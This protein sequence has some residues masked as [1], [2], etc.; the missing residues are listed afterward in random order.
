VPKNQ[1][2]HGASA[3]ARQTAAVRRS[4]PSARSRASATPPKTPKPKAS[5]SKPPAGKSSS[6]KPRPRKSPPGA[7]SGVSPLRTLRWWLL[8]AGVFAALALFVLAY[9]PVARVQYHAV[10]ERSELQAQLAALQARNKR[11]GARVA[12]LETTE[13]IEAEARTQLSMVKKG[14]NLGIVIDGDEKPLTSAAP[15]IDSDAVATAPVGPWT[16]FL[17]AVFGVK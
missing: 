14:E 4:H 15:I 12:A 7:S 6:A 8:P 3:K 1:T 9:Y 2:Q 13:G 11:L 16:A 5:S 10:R 17:D